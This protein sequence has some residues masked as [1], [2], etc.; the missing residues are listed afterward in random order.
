MVGMGRESVV[1][2]GKYYPGRKVILLAM[3][4]MM[5]AFLIARYTVHAVGTI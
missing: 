2:M 5:F 1:K 4:M 3:E